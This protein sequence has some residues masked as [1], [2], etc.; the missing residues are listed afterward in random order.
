MYAHARTY[1]THLYTCTNVQVYACVYKHT[2]INLHQDIYHMHECTC[3]LKSTHLHS[4]K[5][6]HSHRAVFRLAPL[7]HFHSVPRVPG[8]HRTVSSKEQ[9]FVPVT[10]RS[11]ET[12]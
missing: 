7:Q 10:L 2:C 3:T 12:L 4:L 6:S 11:D 8:L 5:V 9:T 1:R